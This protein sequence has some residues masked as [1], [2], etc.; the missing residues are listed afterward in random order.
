M[1]LSLCKN[2]SLPNG[3][4]GLVA[5]AIGSGKIRI[6]CLSCGHRFKPGEGAAPKPIKQ[7]LDIETGQKAN[8]KAPSRH[9]RALVSGRPYIRCTLLLYDL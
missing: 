6:T 2:T 7:K 3:G 8:K 4:I 5:G 9:Y 1:K